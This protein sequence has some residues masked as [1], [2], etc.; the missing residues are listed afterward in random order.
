MTAVYA[1]E[2]GEVRT[3]TRG[4]T[5]ILIG[6]WIAL[7]GVTYLQRF[8]YVLNDKTQAPLCILTTALALYA[9]Y[10]S[11]RVRISSTRLM[12]CCLSFVTLVAALFIALPYQFSPF[13]LYYLFVLYGPFVFICEIEEREYKAILNIYQNL[14]V[15]LA[16]IALVQFAMTM[17]GRVWWDFMDSLPQ[18]FV[19]TDYNTH[20]PL[21]WQSPIIRANAEFFLE[22]SFVSQ[23]MAL[24]V[25]VELVYFNRYWRMALYGGAVLASLS[26]TG[27]V[28][29]LIFGTYIL[30]SRRL[31]VAIACIAAVIAFVLALKH[32]P[33]LDTLLGRA[34]E[35]ESENSSAFIRFVAPIIALD[36]ALGDSFAKWMGGLGPGAV[37]DLNLDGGYA[38]NPFVASKLVIENG[39]VGCLPF[40]AF[41]TYCFFAKKFSYV[42]VAAMYLM[43]EALSGSLQQPHT[44][45]LFLILCILFAPVPQTSAAPAAPQTADR[46]AW[47]P[48]TH[49]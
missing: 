37:K 47:R 18:Q 19:L 39:I 21:A 44:V 20:P 34:T 49:A 3:K 14:L 28:M 25:L 13:S 23:F 15:P 9:F 6:S 7:F 35:F 11:G 10:F 46:F 43:Y 29:L 42:L 12:L 36:D 5:A 24:G 17:T 22:P 4:F 45:Y 40:M 38:V 27:L 16:V 48:P 33:I 31:W 2:T 8:G 41:T 32:T 30:V 1:I 26:G